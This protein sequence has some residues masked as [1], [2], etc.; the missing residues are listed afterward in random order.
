[1]AEITGEIVLTIRTEN[2]LL[3]IVRNFEFLLELQI[4]DHSLLYFCQK[5]NSV[6]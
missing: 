3:K 5:R 4:P 6:T 1:M 2:H